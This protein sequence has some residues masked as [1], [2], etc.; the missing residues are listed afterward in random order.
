MKKLR[1]KQVKTHAEANRYLA[2]EYCDEPNA[3]YARP[4]G[5]PENYHLPGPGA[6]ALG[7]ILRLETERVL[8]N[9]WVVQYQGRLFQV[10]RQSQH[11]APAKSKVTV[12]KWED[13]RL[14][15]QY[16]GQKLKWREITERPVPAAREPQAKSPVK[17]VME[18]GSG[19]SLAAIRRPRAQKL[20]P[21]GPWVARPPSLASPCAS[22]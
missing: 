17:R 2:E 7:E 12:G 8:S 16:R 20:P 4:A 19:P 10:G 21:A 14:E 5:A 9:D 3:H 15:I 1:R 18:A 22:P 6:K 13:G 11:Y